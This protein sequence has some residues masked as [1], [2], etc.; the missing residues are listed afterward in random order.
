MENDQNDDDH[1]NPVDNPED[2]VGYKLPPKH[3][4]WPP[5]YCPNPAG[6]PRKARGRKA[7]L[8]RI[9]YER[10]EVMLGGKARTMTRA[11]AVLLAVRNATANGKP[12][13]HT[14][15]DILLNEVDEDDGDPVPKGVFM[16]PEK[17]SA[18][19]WVAQYGPG[20]EFGKPPKAIRMVDCEHLL[21][22]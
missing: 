17:L 7:I 20:S 14:L 3:S 21:K 11:E 15:Y 1:G 10:I 4:R 5:G 19:E 16:A 18:D 9:A 12:A 22:K 8:E 2:A 13:A 6:R